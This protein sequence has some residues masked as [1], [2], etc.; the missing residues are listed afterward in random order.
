[1]KLYNNETMKLWNNEKMHTHIGFVGKPHGLE[2]RLKLVS[3]E[4]Y[5]EDFAYLEVIFVEEKGGLVPYFIE[6]INFKGV[7]PL[8]KF[9][10]I[11]TREQA[12]KLANKK[13][14]ARNNDLQEREKENPLQYGAY[15]GY[16]LY[17]EQLGEIG[18]IQDIQEFPQ[19]EI[20]FFQY[21]NEEKLIPLNDSLIINVDEEKQLI[22]VNLPEGLLEI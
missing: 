6:N 12:T 10:D 16:T 20:A 8:I 19:Q 7:P 17:D 4:A 11:N 22:I 15:I 3:E 9:E 1:M 14:F 2:G 13:I 18:K 21:N 5:L